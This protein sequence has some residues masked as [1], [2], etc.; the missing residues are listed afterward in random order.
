MITCT[1]LAVCRYKIDYVACCVELVILV[2]LTEELWG[3]PFSILQEILAFSCLWPTSGICMC[4]PPQS[5][6]GI[7]I[8]SNTFLVLLASVNQIKKKT[9]QTTTSFILLLDSILGSLSSSLYCILTNRFSEA[10]CFLVGLIDFSIPVSFC[11]LT[12]QDLLLKKY[13]LES[14]LQC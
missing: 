10:G 1:V 11:I 3:S 2:H 8:T 4:S 5:H 7:E 12:C 6:V 14:G 9:K 13:V